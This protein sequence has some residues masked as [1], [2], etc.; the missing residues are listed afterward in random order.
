MQ[1]TL[2]HVL[3]PEDLQSCAVCL[4]WCLVLGH[5]ALLTSF[6]TP[7]LC[8]PLCPTQEGL[9]LV[10]DRY[11]KVTEQ[12]SYMCKDNYKNNSTSAGYRDSCHH[13]TLYNIHA[14]IGMFV[15]TDE[16][17]LTYAILNQCKSLCCCSFLDTYAFVVL[18]SDTSKRSLYLC[19]QFRYLVCGQ[20][21]IIRCIFG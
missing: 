1:G 16:E 9:C 10:L 4:L 20:D 19:L 21:A 17:I 2:R 5:G 15:L 8:P 12:L 11:L 18:F 3:C 6:T 13:F 14:L 7:T